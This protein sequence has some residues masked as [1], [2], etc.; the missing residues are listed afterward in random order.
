MQLASPASARPVIPRRGEKEF[1]PRAGGGTNLQLHVLDRSR[2]AMFDTLRATR[3]IS[4]YA[5]AT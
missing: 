3:T 4:R 1:E 2:S 5:G